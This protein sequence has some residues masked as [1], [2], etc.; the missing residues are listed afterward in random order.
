M[1]NSSFRRLLPIGLLLATIGCSGGL[2]CGSGCSD[3]YAYAA[4]LPN[5]SAFVD[6][7]VRVRMSQS[8]LDFIVTNLRPILS[9]QFGT[10]PSNP[11]LIVIPIPDAQFA[12][13]ISLGTGQQERRQTRAFIDGA[14]LAERM[15]VQFSEAPQGILVRLSN[16]PF[17]FE[18][19]VF[20]NLD[21]V[22]DAACDIRGSNPEFGGAPFVTGLTF[23]ILISPRVGTGAEC[24]ETGGQGECLKLGID[25]RAVSIGSLNSNAI[26]VVSPPTCRAPRGGTCANSSQCAFGSNCFSGQCVGDGEGPCSEDCS[27][28]RLCTVGTVGCFNNPADSNGDVECVSA[29]GVTNFFVDLAADIVGGIASLIEPLLDDVMERALINALE[30]IDGAPL[31]ASGRLDVAAFAPGILPASALDMG[32]GVQPTGGAAFRVSTPANGTKG[33]DLVLK[34]GFEA[35]I[36]LDPNEGTDVPHPCVRPIVGTEFAGLYGAGRG[37]FNVPDSLL[38][39][40]T[41]RTGTEDYDLGASLSKASLNQALFAL[42]NTGTFCL[43]IDSEAINGL[44]GGGVQLTAATLDLLTQGKLKQYADPS[45]PAIVAINPSQPPVIS[46][47]AGTIDEGHIIVNWPNVEISFYVLMFERFSRVFAVQADISLQ[48]AVFNDPGTET[49]RISVANGPTV[50]NY[51]ENY[52]ELLPGVSFTEVMDSLV[53]IAFDAALGDGLE[54]NYDVGTSLSTLLGIPVFINFQGV[55]TLPANQ[56]EVLNVYLSMDGAPAQPQ[57]ASTT[58]LRLANDPGVLRVAE[59][60]DIGTMKATIPTGRV[61]LEL[62]LDSP[63]EREYFARTDFGAWRGPLRSDGRDLVVKDAKLNLPG[64]HVITVRSRYIDDPN[65]LEADGTEIHVWVDAHAP[66][67]LLEREGDFLVAHGSDDATN[68]ADLVY[69]WK[70]GD[71]AEA[72][73]FAA[74]DRLSL[75]DVDVTRV[76]VVAMDRAGNVSRPSSIDIKLERRRLADER[77]LQT[78][79]ASSCAATGAD[80]MTVGGFAVVLAL[81]LRRRRRSL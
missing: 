39:P 66:R 11:D 1:T 57:M 3:S 7:G 45:A 48:I 76:S 73:D 36:P 4:Q 77:E 46:Y 12:G 58:R 53:G 21:G 38:T 69:A 32:Y 35:A 13:G 54:F 71:T 19:R 16:I 33:M 24:D 30:D 26:R 2:N 15:V 51:R 64:E 23:E 62:E 60:E 56:R 72:G 6:D 20:G 65:S 70:L 47:G 25:V 27:D 80:H 10:D 31:S 8:A 67:V 41:G 74:L 81:V 37:E 22:A 40:L 34:T 42:Y 17:G 5:G 28:N 61:H 59:A 50:G 9:S 29:C 18:G 49:L 44:T 43:E 78:A 14:T 52:N 68:V 75:A 55:E 79:L 63:E